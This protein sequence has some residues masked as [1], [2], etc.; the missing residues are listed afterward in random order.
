MP[1]LLN[2]GIN[3]VAGIGNGTNYT[4][5]VNDRQAYSPRTVYH[6]AGMVGYTYANSS[7]FWVS[8][9]SNAYRIKATGTN[10]ASTGHYVD[11]NAG[12]ILNPSTGI[13]TIS[14]AGRYL[15]YLNWGY[16]SSSGAY[17]QMYGAVNGSAVVQAY[18]YEAGSQ[19]YPG[20]CAT[21]MNLA[22][23][24]VITFVIYQTTGYSW[25]SNVGVG[26]VQ[27]G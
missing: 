25:P 13:I 7:N 6:S 16:T 12:N 3:G 21:V 20:S 2:P 27:L 4:A 9:G 19:D 1:I 14:Q 10:S 5:L 8:L 17:C 24:D 18:H 26:V 23:N 22:A 15:I 11:F